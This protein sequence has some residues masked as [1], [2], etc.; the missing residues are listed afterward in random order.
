[1]FKTRYTAIAAITAIEPTLQALHNLQ[2]PSA[3][4]PVQHPWPPDPRISPHSND[5]PSPPPAAP[6]PV[7][8]HCPGHQPDPDPLHH[9]P[10]RFPA[11]AGPPSD[12]LGRR[13]VLLLSF[14]LYAL[15]SLGLALN[16]ASYGLLLALR[17]L[18]SFGASA[19]LAVAYGVVADVCTPAER[20]GMLGAVMA[21]S[22]LGPC[23]GPVVGGLVAHA[24]GGFA[25]VFWLLVVFGGISLLVIGLWLP[26]TAR[27]VVGDGSAPARRWWQ[28]TGWSV[29]VGWRARPRHGSADE[30]LRGAPEGNG[31]QEREAVKGWR[32]HFGLANP[33]SCLRIIFYR[34]AILVIWMSAS[35]YAVWYAIQASIPRIFAAYGFNE[36]LIGTA[37]LPG[38]AGVVVSGLVTGRVLDYNYK[39][40]AREIGHT[41]DRIGGDDMK[42]FPIER[43]R[44]RDGWAL[45]AIF[46]VI[47]VGYG[48]AVEKEVHPSVPLVLQFVIAFICTY[49]F[50]TFNTL[51]VDV[52]PE[53]PSTAAAAGNV[54]RCV[55]SASA[56]AVL[57]PL[58][59]AMGQGWFFTALSIVAGV[60]G[61]LG[62]LAIITH[63]RK[64]RDKR[65]LSADANGSP[66]KKGGLDDRAILEKKQVQSDVSARPLVLGKEAAD[67]LQSTKS[68]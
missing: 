44:A 52:F 39:R 58:V 28:R 7:L 20:G 64:W 5:L 50:Q 16:V 61:L 67:Q 35:F 21:A 49:F 17:A 68:A 60:C 51:L 26:E 32:A 37:F 30:G 65:A 46:A 59:D 11:T 13:P 9:P 36:L 15:A 27:R 12:A 56:V 3:P 34:D 24:S 53:S 31:E 22:N 10:G 41:V 62:L 2:P 43:A 42:V 25:W 1:M 33:F 45:L 54:S 40:T 66:K 48:W 47:L 55:L 38:G 8:H 23:V 18:Q 6:R 29:L 4:S 19:V 14:T 63:G 57:Q